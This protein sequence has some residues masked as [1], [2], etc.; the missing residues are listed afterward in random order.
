M[1]S[2]IWR[3]QKHK[4]PLRQTDRTVWILVQTVFS[5]YRGPLVYLHVSLKVAADHSSCHST[6]GP[7]ITEL[8]CRVVFS[9]Y[10]GKV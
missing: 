4:S 1:L 10:Y 9:C 5:T 2:Y 6:L 7:I 8:I 3:Q